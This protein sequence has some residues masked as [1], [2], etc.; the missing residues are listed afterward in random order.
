MQLLDFVSTE[1]FKRLSLFYFKTKLWQE[2]NYVHL[3]YKII[4]CIT[5]HLFYMIKIFK[6]K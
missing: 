6:I 2:S 3:S 1:S 4:L 5:K